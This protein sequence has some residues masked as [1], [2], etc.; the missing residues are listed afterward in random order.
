MTSFVG[1]AM[2][3]TTAAWSESW[4]KPDD[5]VRLDG[6]S[7]ALPFDAC[8]SSCHRIR[9]ADTGTATIEPSRWIANLRWRALPFDACV[10]SRHCIR[11]AYADAA[12]IEPSRRIANLRLN[13]F[14][15]PFHQARRTD[16]GRARSVR[17]QRRGADGQL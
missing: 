8:V 11:R 16:A 13:T 7:R 15:M 9:R 3:V 4:N 14:S 5:I 1:T 12:T 17:N 10:S 6:R 2:M